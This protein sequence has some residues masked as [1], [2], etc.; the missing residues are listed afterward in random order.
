MR[1]E[2]RGIML[3]KQWITKALISLRR[4]LDKQIYMSIETRGIILSKQWITKALISLRRCAGWSALLLF[5]YCKNRFSHDMVH[6]SE[7]LMRGEAIVQTVCGQFCWVK[8]VKQLKRV[9][10]DNLAPYGTMRYRCTVCRW[11]VWWRSLCCCDKPYSKTVY[12]FVCCLCV[13]L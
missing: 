6:L 4:T 2:T 5:A 13:G 9:F 8:S 1:I 12:L 7:I 10:K 3:S 11:S